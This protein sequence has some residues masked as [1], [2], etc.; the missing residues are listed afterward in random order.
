M[1]TNIRISK[2]NRD[3]LNELKQQKNVGERMNEN[4]RF[5]LLNYKN[6][7]IYDS[8]EDKEYNAKFKKQREEL[9]N[10]LNRLHNKEPQIIE[11]IKEVTPKYADG[12]SAKWYYNTDNNITDGENEYTIHRKE[13]VEYL[14]GT[15]LYG[16]N[17]LLDKLNEYEKT[18]SELKKELSEK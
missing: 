2:H 12:T 11:T 1:T 3:K 15:I 4:N 5:Y 7:P 6:N 10:L 8:L 9:C 13:P 16:T 18:I 14:D 17:D